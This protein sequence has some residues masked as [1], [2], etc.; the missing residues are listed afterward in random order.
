MPPT[1]QE[2]LDTKKA[3]AYDLNIILKAEPGK[4]YTAEDIEKIIQAYIAGLSQK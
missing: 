2:S 4:T 1:A 3:M